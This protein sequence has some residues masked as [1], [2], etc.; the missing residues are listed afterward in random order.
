M[1]VRLNLPNGT[2]IHRLQSRDLPDLA[3]A[4]SAFGRGFAKV[5]GVAVGTVACVHLWG[6][7]SDIV[8]MEEDWA[9]VQPFL[10][11]DTFSPIMVPPVIGN[12]GVSYNPETDDPWYYGR[13]LFYLNQT[14]GGT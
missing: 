5:R 8:V 13:V 11:D 10:K 9:K 12:P 1:D 3:R 7:G 2:K 4:I 6:G 14:F